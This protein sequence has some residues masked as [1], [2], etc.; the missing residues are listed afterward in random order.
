MNTLHAIL[1]VHNFLL[2][3]ILSRKLI[4]VLLLNHSELRIAN[5]RI[6]NES[7]VTLF[8]CIIFEQRHF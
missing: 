8:L 4:W 6:S 7:R 2:F 3:F 5:D 1:V